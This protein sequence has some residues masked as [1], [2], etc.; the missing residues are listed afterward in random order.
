MA[1]WLDLK[2]SKLSKNFLSTSVHFRSDYLCKNGQYWATHI[3]MWMQFVWGD[4]TKSIHKIY[5]V[6]LFY[7]YSLQ[8]STFQILGSELNNRYNGS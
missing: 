2:P 4:V 1:S 7:P 3:C 8:I 5:F 6:I